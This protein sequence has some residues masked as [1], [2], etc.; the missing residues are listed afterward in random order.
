[1]FGLRFIAARPEWATRLVRLM[2]AAALPPASYAASSAWQF[3][4]TV[5]MLA[6]LAVLL[7][8]GALYA[9]RHIRRLWAENRRVFTVFILW[10]FPIAAF[11][12]WYFPENVHFWA[13]LL[14]PLGAVMA[15]ALKDVQTH[16]QHR[17]P[18]V[19]TAL[20][21]V[22]L[23]GVN[24]VGSILPAHDPTSNWNWDAA[25]FIGQHTKPDE[26]RKSVV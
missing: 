15:L 24:F 20:T 3:V 13:P 18:L 19:L 17:W 26:D 9:L 11:A 1:M 7:A 16:I 5:V 2:P 14:I 23:F 21:V 6:L 22:L 25:R 8:L 4:A 10:T 12:V